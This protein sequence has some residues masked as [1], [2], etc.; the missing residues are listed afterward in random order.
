MVHRNDPPQI[1][2]HERSPPWLFP[3]SHP[4]VGRRGKS[5]S[6][7]PGEHEIAKRRMDQGMQDTHPQQPL[8]RIYP[9]G[10]GMRGDNQRRSLHGVWTMDNTGGG[11]PRKGVVCNDGVCRQI[12]R[13]AHLPNIRIP[14]QR[15]NHHTLALQHQ[16]PSDVQNGLQCTPSDD[17][18]HTST[19]IAFSRYPPGLSQPKLLSL[20]LPGPKLERH[21]DLKRSGTSN[22]LLHP[23]HPVCGNLPKIQ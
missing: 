17:R 8:L 18:S 22:V 21:T 16:S 10:Q 9:T 23:I 12:T 5:P 4:I 13:G 20:P 1:R 14:S 11:V 3:T 2:D 6:H 19:Q 7:P 15:N